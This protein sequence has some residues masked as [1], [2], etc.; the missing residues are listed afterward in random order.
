[1]IED[2]REPLEKAGLSPHWHLFQR[3]KDELRT[4]VPEDLERLVRG[5]VARDADILQGQIRDREISAREAIARI[6]SLTV[7][8]KP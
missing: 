2:Y 5:L 1:M 4:E 6:R 3:I 7:T 8:R